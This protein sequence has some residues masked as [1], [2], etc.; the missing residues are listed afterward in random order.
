[1]LKQAINLVP[2]RPALYQA[3]LLFYLFIASLSIFF[4]ASLI[5]YCTIRVEAFR[6]VLNVYDAASNSMVPM[7]RSYRQLEIPLTFWT[8]TL[9]LV[10]TTALLQRACWLVHRERQ[11]KFRDCLIWAWLSAI[12]FLI[13][14]SCGMVEL[15]SHHFS[16]T[17]GSTKVYGMS[18]SLALI[19]ALH[20]L[21]GIGFLGYVIFQ[22]F[23]NR[24]DHECHH[25]VDHCAGYWHFLDAVWL[26]MLLV[27]VI[28]K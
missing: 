18:F 17:D 3:K 14:Q 11:R 9:L 10:V 12:A 13:L 20:V 6:G 25:P 16:S 28:T 1:M 19:H 24:Y 27:F 7:E 8:S 15:I 5:S 23:R 21:G 4:I 2:A 26:S 22:A